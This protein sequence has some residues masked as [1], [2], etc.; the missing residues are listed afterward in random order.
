MCSLCWENHR[1]RIEQDGEAEVRL[2]GRPFKIKKQFLDDLESAGMNSRIADLKGALLVCHAPMDNTVGIQNAQHIF[3]TA[4]HPRS[5]LSLDDADHLLSNERDSRYAGRVIA[6]WANRYLDQPV[7]QTAVDHGQEGVRIRT[8]ASGYR[9]DIQVGSHHLIA[10]EPAQVGGTDLGPS[11]YDYLNA[12][13]GACT[14]MTLRMYADRKKWPL[15]GV[16]VHLTHAKIHA[17]DCEQCETETGKIDRINRVID[18]EGNLTEE[19]Q[20]RLIEIADRC[21]VHR[22]LH[23][24]IDV[25][26]SLANPSQ[27]A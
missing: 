8:G 5:F 22:T 10:D 16:G 6:E 12:A 1:E 26:T 23:S 25:Q 13:L 19:Q 24:E 3:S 15:E 14:S 4:R 27:K 21:P 20:A 17:E 2:A 9:T 7:Q 11:P 18:L